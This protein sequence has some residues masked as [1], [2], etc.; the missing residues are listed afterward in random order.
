MGSCSQQSG[1]FSIQPFWVELWMNL[2]LYIKWVSRGLEIK[3]KKSLPSTSK[4]AVGWKSKSLVSDGILTLGIY[5]SWAL[6]HSIGILHLLK[7]A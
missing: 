4:R 6:H 7:Q 1:T 2:L 3:L 5:I